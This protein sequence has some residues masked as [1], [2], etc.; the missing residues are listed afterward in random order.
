MPVSTVS[1]I[2]IFALGIAR[3][4]SVSVQFLE[5]CLPLE[6]DLA[7]VEIVRLIQCT[8]AAYPGK[9]SFALF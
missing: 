7:V 9:R 4:L 8:A 5:K 6:Q 1:I 2:D 3:Y